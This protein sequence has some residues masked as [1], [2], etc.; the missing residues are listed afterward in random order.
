M[1]RH[2]RG[3]LR[4]HL[5]GCS[6]RS[7]T[8]GMASVLRRR[9]SAVLVAAATLA[10]GACAYPPAALNGGRTFSPLEPTQAAAEPNGELVRWGR[11]IIACHPG[12]TETCLD[13]V[14]LPL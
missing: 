7:Q 6:D 8:G 10:L 14:G 1:R 3:H 11:T 9:Y 2:V 4:G 12:E 13:V 5:G